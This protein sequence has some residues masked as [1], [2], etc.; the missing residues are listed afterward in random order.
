MTDRS[1]VDTIRGYFYQF[2]LSILSIL[3]LPEPDDSAE[4][5]CI[6]DIDIRTANDVTA[7]QCKYYEKT[8][9]NHSVIKDAIKHM[10]SH[11]KETEVGLKPKVLYSIKGHYASGQEKLDCAID[12]DFLKKHFLTYSEGKGTSRVTRY[13]HTELNLSD[14][15][16]QEF[17]NRLTVDIRAKEFNQQYSDVLTSIRGHFA[18]S[19]FAAEYFYYNSALAVIR[20]LAVR[21]A[22]ADRTITKKEFLARINTSGVLFN[23]WFVEKKGKSAHLAKLRKEYFTQ[24]NVSP[25]ERFFMVEVDMN[26]YLRSDLK[27]LCF[28]L[29]RKWSKLSRREPSPFCPYIYIHGIP[30]N[31]L[32]SLKIE[33]NSEEFRFIDGHDFQG[34]EFSLASITQQANHNNGIKIKVLNT[35]HDAEQTLGKVTKTR[36]IYQFHIGQTYFNYDNPSVQH[37]KIQVEKLSDIKLII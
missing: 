11:F 23:E 28:E 36:C 12:L 19:L 22:S 1:A 25:Y 4:I 17:L 33:L 31:E 15:E 14:I 5:E 20:Q 35:L 8:E 27:Q 6:E 21:V 24:L 9:Y 2:D 30:A 26:S 37:I 13:H 3:Q 18:C 32:L 16:L 29:S 34:A 10:L 7:L